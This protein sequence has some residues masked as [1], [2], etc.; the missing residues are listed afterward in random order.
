MREFFKKL[1]IGE[2]SSQRFNALIG[3]FVASVVVIYQ[4]AANTLTDAIF[5]LYLGFVIAGYAASKAAD[6]YA[7]T[8]SAIAAKPNEGEDDAND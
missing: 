6:A 4:A 2:Y 3:V 8:H 5:G 1:I 7:E